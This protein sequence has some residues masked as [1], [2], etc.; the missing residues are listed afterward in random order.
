M[1]SFNAEIVKTSILIEVVLY[2]RRSDKTIEILPIDLMRGRSFKDSFIIIDESQNTTSEQLDMIATRIDKGSIM[3]FTGDLDQIDLPENERMSFEYFINDIKH[4]SNVGVCQLTQ[5][6]I[7]R[8][9]IVGNIILAR[10]NA[11]NERK[12]NVRNH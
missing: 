10:N 7:Q 6:D 4:L 5:E 2:C 12:K 8:H 9:P 1:K 11:K 3:V